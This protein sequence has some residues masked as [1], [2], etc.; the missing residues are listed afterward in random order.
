MNAAGRRPFVWLT[1]HLKSGNTWTRLLLANFLADSEQA[2]PST[3]WAPCFRSSCLPEASMKQ[4]WPVATF[5]M[6][7][8]R[9]F[10]YP[11]TFCKRLLEG[12]GPWRRSSFSRETVS[13]RRS[14]RKRS[15]CSKRCD[16]AARSIW[17]SR[18]RTSAGR[19]SI[20]AAT[21]CRRR[22]WRRR[23]PPTRSS[24]AR[25][26]GRSGRAW[27][28]RCAPSGG[29]C[30]CGRRLAYSPICA[31]SSCTRPLPAHRPCAARWWR[32]LTSSSCA[33][34]PAE[35]TS[36]SRAAFASG[37]GAGNGKVSTPWSTA[38]RRS[39]GS[40]GWPSIWLPG[41]GA[42]SA[43]WTRP[44]CWRRASC[45]ARSPGRWPATTR[46]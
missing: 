12:C 31:P 17:R 25:W 38:N 20:P 41:A 16:R 19:R 36:G 37:R 15:R 9:R 44:T 11:V 34:S 33:S 26:A 8:M 39:S 40:A 27:T 6:T 4:P 46:R 10:R 32:V 14:S 3:N 24:S 5:R 1:S 29:C 30:A 23:R 28:G 18:S 7:V 2:C 45:G 42:G 13:A 43:R 21:R 22:P 35:S